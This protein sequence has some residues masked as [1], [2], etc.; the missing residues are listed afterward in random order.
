M[1]LRFSVL[2]ALGAALAGCSGE[3]LSKTPDYSG[4]MDKAYVTKIPL[5]VYSRGD[6]FDGGL[7]I[8]GEYPAPRLEDLPPGFPQRNGGDMWLGVLPAGSRLKIEKV[9]TRWSTTSG[10]VTEFSLRIVEPGN[11]SSIHIC[12]SGLIAYAR[13]PL[14]L[15][16]ELFDEEPLP[17]QPAAR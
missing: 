4:V 10:E 1:E 11:Y 5:L 16:P 6:S 9:N 13:F 8:P 7:E 17:G 12:D 15:K 3:D 14:R 2:L